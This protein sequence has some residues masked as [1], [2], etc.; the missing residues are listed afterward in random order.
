MRIS[1][2]LLLVLLSLGCG[3]IVMIPGGALSGEVQATPADWKFTDSIETVQ[4]ETRPSDPY[5]VN[6][7]VVASGDSLYFA[8]GE[9]EWAGYVASDSR[10][11]LRV[12]GKLYELK[13]VQ[14]EVAGERTAVLAAMK[15][16]YDF[17]PD[18]EQEASASLYRL[19][20]R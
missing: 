10:V 2:M 12:D 5:S 13:A 14:T 4:L 18:A 19:E 16:K 3:P 9:T 6:I 17:E 15:R 7:W 8:T 20:A 1:A 11:R